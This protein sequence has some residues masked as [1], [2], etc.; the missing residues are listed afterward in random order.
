MIF[1]GCG[2]EVAFVVALLSGVGLSA[3]FYT[4][5]R[6]K[7]SLNPTAAGFHFLR[8]WFLYVYGV[9]G[10]PRIGRVVEFLGGGVVFVV[11]WYGSGF[12]SIIWPRLGRVV[13]SL[14]GLLWVFV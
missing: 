10:W 8:S 2:L 9:L 3:V 12:G 13:D 6:R 14:V 7:L 1:F 11:F 5:R 4:E